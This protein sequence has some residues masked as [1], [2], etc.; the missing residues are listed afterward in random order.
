MKIIKNISS[1]QQRTKLTNK[2][3][4]NITPTQNDIMSP[5]PTHKNDY[6]IESSTQNNENVASSNLQQDNDDLSW[7]EESNS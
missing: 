4:N 7:E 2:T 5:L 3:N 6:T 1:L